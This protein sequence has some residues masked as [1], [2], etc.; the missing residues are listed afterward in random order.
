[1]TPDLFEEMIVKLTPRLQKKTTDMRHPLSVGL[2]VAVTLRFLASGC[3]YADLSYSFRVSKSAIS[4]FVP[5]VCQA[6]I[7]VYMP[8]VLKCP[9]TPEEWKV[10]ADGFSRKWNYHNCCGAID[11]KHIAIQKP[12]NAGS[13]YYNYKK[14]HS[15]ILMGVSDANYKFIYVDIG[16]E[17]GAGDAGTW[18]HSTFHAALERNR[19]GFPPAAPLPDDDR[20]IPFHLV[21]DDAFAL[22]PWLMKPYSQR[23]QEDHQKI[24]SYRLSR[25]RRVVENT[26]GL[27]VAVFR[28]FSTTILMRPPIVRKITLCGVVLHNLLLERKPLPP[29]HML[30]DHEDANHN[31]VAGAWREYRAALHG[32]DIANVPRNPLARAKLQRDYLAHYYTSPI[33]AVPWQERAA[34]HRPQF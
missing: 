12:G 3:S 32:L 19:A 8:E 14:F 15:I 5:V 4:R 23:G 29:N 25:A 9:T 16:A 2:K 10:V 33:G 26:F 22:K 7:D 1:M 24:F 13:Q 28:I 31:E 6:I 30:L 17:G 21:A 11:G 34:L 27:L 20:P 18:Y